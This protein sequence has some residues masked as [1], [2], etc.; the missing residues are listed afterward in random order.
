MNCQT[1]NKFKSR[2][3]RNKRSTKNNIF[4]AMKICRFF[5][6]TMFIAISACSVNTETDQQIDIAQ[7]EIIQDNELDMIMKK[8]DDKL[9]DL[10]RIESMVYYKEDASSVEAT[11]YLDE[12]NLITK[13]TQEHLDGPTGYKTVIQ[14]YSNK[15]VR[16]ASRKTSVKVAN[17]NPYFSEEITFYDTNG[18]PNYSKERTAEYEA[19]IDGQYFISIDTIR[20]NDKEAFLILQQKDTY[21]TTFQGFVESGP[22]HFLIVG[23]NTNNDSYTASLS[24]QED[25]PTLRYLRQQGKQALGTELHIEFERYIDP[26]GYMMQIL[27]SV[28]LVERK[29][30][31]KQQ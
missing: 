18:I 13:I 19:N 20:H 25:S 26:T 30:Q 12:N 7:S 8:I 11:A 29:T 3:R 4:V 23:G 6:Y 1:L 14:F 21:A 28:S 15:G 24:I 27:R 22:F 2:Y 5:S 16:F 9:P 17:E 31:N 10:T